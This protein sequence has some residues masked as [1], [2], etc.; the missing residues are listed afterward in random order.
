MDIVTQG[1][2]GA[3]AAQSGGN[4]RDVRLAAFGG[5]AAAML[6]DADVL[7]R[8]DADPLL[9]LEYHRHFSHALAFIPIGA[10]IASILLW[11]VLRG[12]LT[13]RRTYWFALLGYATAGV[14][15][16][17][18][19]YGTRLL[20]PF[21]D[22]SISWSIVAVVDPLFSAIL[23]VS[24]AIA[25]RTRNRH[26]AWLGVCLAVSYLGF[27]AIQHQRALA[28]AKALASQRGQT[29]ERVL[30]KPTMGNVLLWRSLAINGA[31]VNI[32]AVRVGL[33][34]DTRVYAGTTTQLVAPAT[35]AD[36]PRDSLA[37]HELQRFHGYSD[38]LLVAHPRDPNYI[39]D[40]RY[41][42]LPTG[43]APLWGIELDPSRPNE[44]I[45]FTTRREL[46]PVMRNR[47]VDMLLGRD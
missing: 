44:P 43:I 6:A 21:S 12:R 31:S 20:W 8:S 23:I 37:Y 13:W 7:I 4:S 10:L 15:D 46:T 28:V 35:W 33:L 24:L 19:S 27:G 3:V 42:M 36:L 5:A 47:F 11:P 18:T 38:H 39:G 22:V 25:W 32:D 1:L 16:A 2:L 9:V 45:R 30:V 26:S 41:A 29:P 40:L 14:L 17:C 34:G